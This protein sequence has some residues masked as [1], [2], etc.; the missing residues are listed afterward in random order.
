MCDFLKLKTFMF[1]KKHNLKSGKAKIRKRDFKEKTRQETPQKRKDWWQ[2]SF[3]I[4]YFDVVLFMKQKQ[5]RKKNKE[6]DKNKELKE[7]KT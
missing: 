3:V 7:S 1:N 6:T 2:T 4:E 5:V